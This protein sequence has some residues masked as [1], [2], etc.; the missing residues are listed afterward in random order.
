MQPDH[1]T[2]KAM[3]QM[4]ANCARD[5]PW[6]V[7]SDVGKD[8]ELVI[9][10]G[11]P[12]LKTRLDA[13]KR[14]QKD[15]ACVFACNGAARLLIREGIDPDIIGF[16]DISPTVV[17]FIPEFDTGAL[18]LVAS[19]V[20]PSVLDA[21]MFRKVVLWHADYGE[22]RNADAI[23]ILKG[24]PE[25]P[26]SLIGGGNTIALRAQNIGFLLGFRDIHYYGLD[27]SFSEDGADHAYPKHDGAEPDSV[28][29]LFAAKKYRCS[30][31][32]AQQAQ[33]FE[34][35]Y[36]Q[37]SDAGVKLTVHGDGLIPDIWRSIRHKTKVA[38]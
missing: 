25:K 31:W 3:A 21:L 6:F 22:G 1:S 12:S 5:L 11:G 38:A 14:R 26:G 36:R 7:G 29:I 18:Y 35:Y 15:G 34:F 9:V 17:G 16:V 32:M 10:A 30:P 19:V 28:E 4:R 8:K 23:K 33:E 13:V 27:S 24:H 2:A 20:S 37:M